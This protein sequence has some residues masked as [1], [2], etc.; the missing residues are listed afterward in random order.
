[1]FDAAGGAHAGLA[2]I[3]RVYSGAGEGGWVDDLHIEAADHATIAF[4]PEPASLLILALGGAAML[5]R[6]KQR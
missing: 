1:M 5:K 2:L 6:Q 3:A 4:A